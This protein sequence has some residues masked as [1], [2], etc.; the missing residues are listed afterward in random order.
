MSTRSLA[1]IGSCAVVG[2]GL[3]FADARTSLSAAPYLGAVSGSAVNLRTGGSR[4]HF[5]FAQVMRGQR[6]VVAS[7]AN[8]WCKV[9]IPRWL[10]VFVHKDYVQVEG[11]RGVVS[12][13]Q[14]K[15][16]VV[17]MRAHEEVG[18][19][20]RGTDVSVL[21]REG[22]WIKITPSAQT[23][24]YITKDHVRAVRSLSPSEVEKEYLLLTSAPQPFS[25]G[26]G[27]GG[28]T[29]SRPRAG[30]DGVTGFGARFVSSQLQ[31]AEDLLRAI[32]AKAPAER[33]Y[34][35]VRELCEAVKASSEDTVEV[36]AAED[37]LKRI[38]RLEERDGLVVGAEEAVAE[39]QQKNAEI[40]QK[41]RDARGSA[42]GRSLGRPVQYPFL[43]SGWLGGLSRFGGHDGTHRLMKGSQVL[44]FLKAEEG[45]GIDLDPYLNK[46]VGIR[47]VVKEL[48]PKFEANL[49]LVGEVVVLSD[50]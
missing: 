31:R 38:E 13:N 27:G 50:Q 37:A 16:R 46:R 33:D 15:V 23:Y 36:R 10:P 7:E 5:P 9:L 39:T 21:G 11:S 8:G 30:S 22:D 25:D 24:G 47:G 4:N 40:E 3:L 32:G 48:D 2:L 29:G 44:Y 34:G 35:P 45:K 49:I 12:A 43:A 20:P 28:A 6:V 1:R 17:A 19:L 26:P 14:L 42:V 41:M 18:T